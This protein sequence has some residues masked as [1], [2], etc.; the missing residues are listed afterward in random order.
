MRE[1]KH[2]GLTAEER[3]VLAEPAGQVEEL[4]FKMS[5]LAFLCLFLILLLMIFS[6]LIA[7]SRQQ[8]DTTLLLH[9]GAGR[10]A[11]KFLAGKARERA[12]AH[13]L[14]DGDSRRSGAFPQTKIPGSQR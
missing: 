13:S 12:T 10:H 7:R 3:D 1:N 2:H 5:L 8:E 11:E 14:D 9:E 4:D 6:S